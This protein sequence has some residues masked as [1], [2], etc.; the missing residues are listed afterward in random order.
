[1]IARELRLGNYVYYGESI[2][3]ITAIVETAQQC[4]IGV[5]NIITMIDVVKPIPLTPE[6]LEKCGF[7]NNEGQFSHPDNNDFDLFFFQS[8]NLWCAY[9]FGK[10]GE[11]PLPSN[12]PNA[13]VYNPICNPFKYLHQ[14]QNLYYS[15]TGQELTP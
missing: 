7:E 3:M 5:D 10:E 14:L 9:N 2:R 8:G 13:P 15:L 6:I 12:Y 4:K 1:M 11:S